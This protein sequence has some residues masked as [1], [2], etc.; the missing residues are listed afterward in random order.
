MGTNE[1]SKLVKDKVAIKSKEKLKGF[2]RDAVNE[3]FTEVLHLAEVSVDG[4][5]R[6]NAL[7]SKI[8]TKGNGAIRTIQ[9]ELDLFYNIEYI[10]NKETI[11]IPATSEDK[12]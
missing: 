6:Y 3:F 9:T 8:L 10:P 2:V 12:K 4:R 1:G 5:D 11:I 7:R